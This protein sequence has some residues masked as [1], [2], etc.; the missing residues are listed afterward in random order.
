MIA[1]AAAGPPSRD[2]AAGRR[3]MPRSTLTMSSFTPMTPVDATST[4]DA[5]AAERA[6]P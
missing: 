3:A 5:I 1:R 4:S 6:A 2:S